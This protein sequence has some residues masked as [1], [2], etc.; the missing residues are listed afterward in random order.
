MRRRLVVAVCVLVGLVLVAGGPFLAIVNDDTKPEEPT[1]VLD[2]ASDASARFIERYV[3]SDGRVVRRD[4]GDDT[5]SEGQAYAMLVAVATGDRK[6]F[7]STWNWAKANLR[8]PNG[9]FAWKWDDGKVEDPQPATDADMDMA[10]ALSIAAERFGE[11]SYADEARALAKAIVDNELFYTDDNRPVVMAGPWAVNEPRFTNPSYHSP[12]AEQ[13]LAG[14]TGDALW[15]TI[16]Q[17]ER[18]LMDR[19]IGSQQQPRLPSD[20]AKLE[21]NG[22]ITPSSPPGK[23][24]APVYSYDAVRT[25]V[26]LA[27]SCDQADRDQAMRLWTLL[28]ESRQ[29]R[30]SATL[31]LDGDVVDRTP[32]AP[33]AVGS[34]AAAKAAGDTTQMNDLLDLAD[35]IDTSQNS[36]Y[37]AAWAALGR[38]MLTTDWLGAC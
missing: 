14:L 19:L 10:R 26:R 22:N 18:E 25:P 27:E 20:W 17:R 3:D 37:G 12:R 7:D 28:N 29:T 32:S 33:A 24:D 1:P 9:L 31:S 13:E 8:Q 11:K 4:Q 21:A 6:T 5:V 16:R 30:S 35:R 38:I 36:Y 15:N 23:T 2:A 34:A